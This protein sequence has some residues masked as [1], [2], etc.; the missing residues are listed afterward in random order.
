M[1]EVSIKTHFSAAHH[2]EGYQGKCETQHG[3]NWDVEV[4]VRG[5]G[6]DETGI[7]ID[8]RKLRDAVDDVM[9]KLDHRDLNTV[10][11]FKDK[12]PTSENIATYLY[13]ELAEKL[14]CD[15]YSICRVSVNETPGSKASYWKENDEL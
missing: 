4:F 2:L 8:F 3:H 1:F 15:A 11:A 14:N 5:K 6:L 7:L 13:S 12:N 9:N 10:V